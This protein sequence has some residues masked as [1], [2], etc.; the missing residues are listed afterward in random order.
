MRA[1]LLALAFATDGYQAV[2]SWEDLFNSSI[3]PKVLVAIER[4]GVPE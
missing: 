1:L 2:F 3:G 4:D